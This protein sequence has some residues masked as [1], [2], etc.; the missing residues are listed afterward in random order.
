MVDVLSDTTTRVW[1][2]VGM[3]AVRRVKNGCSRCLSIIWRTRVA[4][5][6]TMSLWRMDLTDTLLKVGGQVY[7]DIGRMC[8]GLVITKL[9]S[10]IWADTWKC[11]HLEAWTKWL[12]FCRQ[13]FQ[14]SDFFSCMK[15]IG[16]WSRLVP[17]VQLIRQHWN[18]VCATMQ[19]SIIWTHDD[20]SLIHTCTCVSNNSMA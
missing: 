20:Q 17:S 10:C 6:S 11:Y 14:V 1:S 4:N 8:A 19:Q 12:P 9:G 3:T 7:E 5:L 15:T 2:Q 13:Q 16:I 18:R